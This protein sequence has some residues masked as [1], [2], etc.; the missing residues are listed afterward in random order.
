LHVLPVYSV[1]KEKIVPGCE[2]LWV[3]ELGAAYRKGDALSLCR[4]RR[5]LMDHC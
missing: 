2:E 4:A 1:S 5:H 3:Q